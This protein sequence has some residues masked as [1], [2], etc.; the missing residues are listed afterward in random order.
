[1]TRTCDRQAALAA[2]AGSRLS[3]NHSTLI[4][5]CGNQVLLE[6]CQR[7]SDGAQLY[8]GWSADDR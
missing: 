1:M 8:R 3:G 4:E 5:A 2:P 7:L 6:I